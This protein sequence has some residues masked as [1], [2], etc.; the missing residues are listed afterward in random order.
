MSEQI[1]VRPSSCPT[2]LIPDAAVAD[3]AFQHNAVAAAIA[4]M[5]DTE[6]GG[7]AIALT[8]SWGSGKSTVVRLLEKLLKSGPT[9]VWTFVFDAWSH[10]GDPLRRTFLEKLIDWAQSL[11]LLTSP[12]EFWKEVEEELAW[13]K[14]KT[15]S[16]TTPGLAPWGIAV[17]FSLLVAPVAMQF[18]QKIQYKWH[19]KWA[20]FALCLSAAPV[21]LGLLAF[22][23][24]WLMKRDVSLSGIFL[25]S[26][27]S[28]TTSDTSKTPDPT[29][30]EFE[31]HYRKLLAEILADP[32]RKVLL[33]IDNLDR[34]SHDD[35][36]SIWATLRIFFDP[37]LQASVD[38][39][40]RVWVLVPFDPSGATHLWESD[41]QSDASV[42]TAQH[43]LEKTFVTTFHVPPIVF[44]NWEEFL[45]KQLRFALP[46][47]TADEFH[48]VFRLFDHILTLEAKPPTPRNM[49][50]FVNDLG[51]LHRQWQDTIPLAEQAL[52]VLLSRRPTFLESLR[53]SGTMPI[54]ATTLI[55]LLTPDWQQNLVAIYFNVEP[56]VAFQELLSQPINRALAFGNAK[57]LGN[58]AAH[59]AFTE[60]LERIIEKL[61]GGTNIMEPQILARNALAVS[62]LGPNHKKLLTP[63]VRAARAVEQWAPL[64][65][66]MV[67]GVLR[68]INMTPES[69]DTSHFVVS[70]SRSLA[71]SP[72]TNV[73]SNISTWCAAMEATIP[74]L[75]KRNKA[76]VK[77]SFRVPG[78]PEQF[79]TVIEEA[80]KS[81]GGQA[82]LKYFRPVTNSN[83]VLKSLG[84]QVSAGKWQ[85]SHVEITAALLAT[86]QTWNWDQLSSALDQ[87]MTSSLQTQSQ[88]MP[89]DLPSILR[90]LYLLSPHSNSARQA[91]EK[92]AKSEAMLGLFHWLA[93]TDIQSASICALT[94]YSIP[95][96]LER[97]DNSG[98]S[99]V[100]PAFR[101]QQGR[102]SLNELSR[103]PGSNPNLLKA[104]SE[105]CLDWLPFSGWRKLAQETPTRKQ[106]VIKMLQE[107]TQGKRV[108]QIP[109]PELVENIPFWR[110]LLGGETLN[111]ALLKKA[112]Q[113]ELVETIK[114]KPFTIP[115]AW[116]HLIA[117][118]S[119]HD[120]VYQQ[121][122]IAGI[123]QCTADQWGEAMRGET[124]LIEIALALADLKIGLDQSF[125]DALVSHA[126]S[127]LTQSG[128]G[129]LASQWPKLLKL[130]PG[131]SKDA[132]LQAVWNIIWQ[133]KGSVLG[134]IPYYGLS[135]SSAILEHG[136]EEAAE[137]LKQ[138]IKGKNELE[139][140]WLSGVLVKW[141]PT[142]KGAVATRS[143]LAGRV[144]KE[145]SGELRDEQRFA[146]E[147]LLEVLQP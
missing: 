108:F 42:E 83:A 115:D 69:E 91:L 56:S 109:T 110:E 94:T 142:D 74:I 63:L 80:N 101:I 135:L 58:L 9:D 6:P 62:G 89:S 48:K 131:A 106:I 49:K 18:Y 87:K 72:D 105:K 100:S 145:L 29:S 125:S 13:R 27:E 70:L 65:A 78:N 130:L 92:S 114:K 53:N 77:Q 107:V 7:C 35:A 15:K 127:R 123:R 111:G 116:M 84:D 143:D 33:V 31:K 55:D 19:P 144:V 12:P 5:I 45:C 44:S 88:A 2:R 21:F 146:L 112:E 95:L 90:T 64:D 43:F 14:E 39:Y 59:P 3:D 98:Y 141:K 122:I 126:E 67:N 132:F 76:S 128:T 32:K 40:N 60:V 1:D 147:H 99:P 54:I 103:N 118:R 140:K 93:T 30:V 120:D 113:G 85:E 133:G 16:K 124:P 97:L 73:K 20:V 134:L 37:A 138:I 24:R 82:I 41:I 51:A 22:L 117:L 50:I 52:F 104:M 121:Q 66:T 68:L 71:L 28:E 86:G 119:K 26:S 81:A 61:Y 96:A 38:W 11:D 102:R 137:R 34:V 75:A 79:I 10:Q 23:Y 4:S 8:G 17:A 139:L 25:S 36:R 57:D 129:P 47:H 46:N 136:P